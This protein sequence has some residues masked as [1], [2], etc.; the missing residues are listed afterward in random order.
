MYEQ[1]I[2]HGDYFLVT[3]ESGDIPGAV[4][5]PYADIPSEHVESV[6]AAHTPPLAYGLYKGDTRVLSHYKLR[7]EPGPL[8]VT[9]SS[10]KAGDSGR[11]VMLA[12][13]V[14][15]LDSPPREVVMERRLLVRDGFIERITVRNYGSETCEL[16]LS[17]DMAADFRDIF[18]VRGMQRACRGR[19]LP[20]LIEEDRV[21]LHYRG[22]DEVHCVTE[23]HFSPPPS[24][25]TV[26]SV[27]DPVALG[28][29][30]RPSAA[31]DADA[32]G[33]L[34]GARASYRLA[35]QPGAEFAFEVS[36]I[37]AGESANETPTE[38]AT[39]LMTDTKDKNAGPTERNFHHKPHADKPNA[40]KPNAHKPNAHKPHAAA[41]LASR[42]DWQA[43]AQDTALWHTDH[44]TINDVL[45]RSF[46]DVRMLLTD[47]GHGPMPVAGI[48]WYAAPFGRDSLVTAIQTLSLHPGIAAATLRTLAAWQG[49]RHDPT[50]DEEPGK[51]MHELRRGEMARLRE[52]P[53]VPYFGT[54][55]ATP[56]FIIAAG[57]YWRWTGDRDLIAELL[58]ALHAAVGWMDE[59]GDLD[60]DGYIEYHRRYEGGL[61]NQ[62]WKDSTDGIVHRDRRPAR[63]PIALAEVQGYAYA[64]RLHFADILES[65]GDAEAAVA[66]RQRAAHLKAAFNEDFW[67]EAT[68]FYAL[69]L[70]GEKRPVAAVSSNP[71]H[72]LWTGIIVAERVGTVAERLL[73]E[74]M[75]TGYGIR[76]LSAA[77]TA[78][79]PLS[80]HRGSVWP[81]DNSLIAMGLAR[82]GYG[83]A[84]GR[85]AMGLFTA[86][87]FEP[88]HRL[89][90]LFGGYAADMEGPVWYPVACTPQA[91]AAAAPF[92]LL[93]AVLGLEPDAP[94][95]RV[96]L[97][98]HLPP[99]INRVSALNVRIGPRRVR[100]EV[101]RRGDGDECECD[102]D[103]VSGP[104]LDV[105][106]RPSSSGR[107]AK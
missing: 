80:Y 8:N 99:G 63:P 89:P 53:F 105:V 24:A 12:D 36:I 5:S 50:H 49:R 91:W 4:P 29:A 9:A 44:D 101:Q 14:T 79:H 83:D 92:L 47:F 32:T 84:A 13:T 93:Q 17:L 23:V 68:G 31:N 30:D 86:A 7:L 104:P 48:P 85:I 75:F 107:P 56:L 69:A 100:I 41:M 71:G 3:T 1:V 22:L 20:V 43:W 82:N 57:E 21:R 78:Y 102:V 76:T 64:A 77:E 10:M 70:D 98:P 11:I 66:Q 25:F 65:F 55:D 106:I 26:I 38:P 52:I 35:L 96:A 67:V 16:Q 58:P 2:K 45:D 95:D 34:E 61:V 46:R 28:S 88:N 73:A 33:L 94:S 39:E 18:E 74:D 97:S 87:S 40:H 72:G 37:S 6:L 59:H 62:G 19:M 60:G 54:V 103:V 51:I 15:S 27:P 42:L 81:H 90:E